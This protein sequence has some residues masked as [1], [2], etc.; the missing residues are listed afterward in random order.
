MR[1]I[2]GKRITNVNP[3]KR[4]R[5]KHQSLILA[6]LIAC[7]LENAAQLLVCNVNSQQLTR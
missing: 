5:S 1:G 3:R 6:L 7:W 2:M 4:E